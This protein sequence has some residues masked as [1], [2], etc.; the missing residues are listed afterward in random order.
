MNGE[1]DKDCTCL[2]SMVMV[3]IVV[4]G[5]F[6]KHEILKNRIKLISHISSKYYFK[7]YK[8]F[9]QKS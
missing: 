3:V 4:V 8:L 6:E 7:I 9:I 1:E 2:V 5:L